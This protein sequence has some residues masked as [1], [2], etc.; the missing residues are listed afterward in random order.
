M[1]IIFIIA[2]WMASYSG[3]QA[4]SVYE[5]IMQDARYSAGNGAY[6]PEPAEDGLTA[7]P[8]GKKAFYIS[9]YGSHGARYLN[10]AEDY[11]AP[12][13]VLLRADSAGC[14]TPLGRDVMHRLETIKNAVNERWGEL[15]DLG[16]QQQRDIM[17]R[18]IN[19][20]PDVYLDNTYIEGRS[21]STTRCILSMVNAVTQAA[22]MRN[23]QFYQNATQRDMHYMNM[24]IR[25]LFS[26]RLDRRSQDVYNAFAA[27]Y[28]G[29]D[30]LLSTFISDT[31]YARHQIDADLFARDLFRVAGNVQNLELRDTLMLFDL[32]TTDE[33]YRLWKRE[34][35]W[36]YI[37]NGAAT[38][39]GGQKPFSQRNL[40]QKMIE[41]AD[42]SMKN[43]ERLV[44]LR[45]GEA[46][47]IIPLVCLLE[48]G[49]YGLATDDLESLDSLGWVD[50]R[51][52]PAGANLQIVFYRENSKDED[53]LLKVLLNEREI[54][55]P[56]PTDM[57][58]YYHWHDFRNYYL[59][60]LDDYSKK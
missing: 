4:Q 8:A 54:T 34:N 26:L 19:R 14:L 49:C 48:A 38:T 30:R 60:K 6:Y 15:T 51:I 41:M 11:E 17:R 57:P 40:L 9:H 29:F 44:Q 53:V 59:K 56:L 7:P 25:R 1:R 28:A 22:Q 43:R 47:G 36:V 13:T 2:V 33:L 35:A 24:Q 46:D 16:A 27:K 39:N 21:T 10:T 18:M 3:I 37:N 32:F 42:S 12:L 23:L 45:Y 52:S 50:Y 20:F 31:A 55:L 58:P 5:E